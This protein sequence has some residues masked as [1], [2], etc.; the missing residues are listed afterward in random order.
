MIGRFLLCL[1]LL[2]CAGCGAASGPEA[3]VDNTEPPESF[4][5]DSTTW[6]MKPVDD[7]ATKCLSRFF[8]RNPDLAGSPEMDGPPILF[9]ADQDCRFYWLS[10][11]ADGTT[12]VCVAF[13]GGKFAL[14]EGQGDPFAPPA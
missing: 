11:S 6:V 8:A 9:A 3:L 2:F 10:A 7:E 14:S 13:E 1:T 12:W 4:Q 5:R